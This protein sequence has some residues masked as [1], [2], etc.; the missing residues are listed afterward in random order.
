MKQAIVLLLVTV[1][2]IPVCAESPEVMAL[3]DS[4]AV[5]PAD[6]TAVV[7]KKHPW[8]AAAEIVGFNVAL[9]GF[10][11]VFYKD[12]DW[13]HVTMEHIK[14]NITHRYWVW[15]HEG[16]GMNGFRHP[17]HGSLYYLTARANWMSV[18]E[19]SL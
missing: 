6:T 15:D 5:T 17:V 10:N 3:D 9:V 14:H 16:L 13:S 18:G 2:A 11:S 12:D 4:L 19:S 8:L 7:R 1:L